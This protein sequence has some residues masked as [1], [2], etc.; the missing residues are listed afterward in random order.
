MLTCIIN[1]KDAEE[2]IAL[3]IRIAPQP[4]FLINLSK[5]REMLESVLFPE[6]SVLS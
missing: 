3:G 5:H 2:Y 6:N 4:E 1:I